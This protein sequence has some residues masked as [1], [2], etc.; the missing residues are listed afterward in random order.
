MIKMIGFLGIS[1]NYYNWPQGIEQLG[2][3]YTRIDEFDPNALYEADCFYQTNM[4]KPKFLHGD[5]LDREGAKYLYIKNS[6]KPVLVSESAPFRKYGG[7]LR[8]GWNSYMWT[9]ANCNNDNVGPQRWKKFEKKTG[10][11]FVDWHSPG[12]NILIM[13]QK[14]GDSALVP[15]FDEGKVFYD[16]VIETILEIRKY[17]DRPIVFRPHPRTA[18]RGIKKL[19]R[20]IEDKKLVNVRLSD[21]ISYGGNQGGVGLDAD[22]DSAY[23]VITFNSLSGI[24]AVE[25]G[26]PVFALNNGSMVYP[27][28]HTDLS[29]IENLNY[30]IDLQ[31]WKNK[32]AYTIWNKKEVSNGECWAHLKPV[33][34]S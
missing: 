12:D 5:R 15:L 32:I 22:L 6:G 1:K 25:K 7:Y 14:E 8:F 26:I 13:G 2:D 3:S 23:C 17:S 9:D 34:F 33:Y 29:E 21:N 28:A 18:I 19:T 16:W 4:V 20:L 30:S 27:I 24:E 10:I 31:P 11:T